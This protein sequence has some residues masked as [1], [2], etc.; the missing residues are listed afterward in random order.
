MKQ[1]KLFSGANRQAAIAPHAARPRRAWSARHA[2]LITHHARA[3]TLI[4]LLVVIAIIAILA[5]LLLPAL[6]KAK[7]QSQAVKC[8]SNSRQLMLGWIQYYT[9]NNDR[10]VNNF[11][12]LFAAAEEENQT[13]HI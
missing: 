3:F 5:A 6:N 2:A 9:D 1:A 11:G 8:M 13:Y 10:L 12:G 4:E 7:I